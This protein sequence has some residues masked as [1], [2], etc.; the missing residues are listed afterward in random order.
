MTATITSSSNKFYGYIIR[1]VISI[2]TAKNTVTLITM[3]A[4]WESTETHVFALDDV[5]IT[6]S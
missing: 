4:T 3:N 5:V 1:D 2:I 6:I